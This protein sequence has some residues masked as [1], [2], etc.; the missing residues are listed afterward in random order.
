M[1]KEYQVTLI[2]DNN[3]YKAVS[4]VVK[5][6]QEVD[7]DMSHSTIAK[8]KIITKGIERICQK[9]LWTSK[10]LSNYGYTIAK[11][12]LY[13]KEKIA[14]AAQR[15]YDEIKEAKYQSG[16]WKRPKSK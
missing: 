9:R 15:R 1:I 5:Y 14:A 10:D 4:T 3:K 6:E 16:E 2:C 7:Y 13:D 12:R 8:K 11:I